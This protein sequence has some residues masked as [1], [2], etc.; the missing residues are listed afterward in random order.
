MKNNVYTVMSIFILL[1]FLVFVLVTYNNKSMLGNSERFATDAAPTW[2]ATA[3]VIPT[4]NVNR[5]VASMAPTNPD[6]AAGMGSPY[7]PS[8]GAGN[9]VYNPVMGGPAAGFG[10]VGGADASGPSSTCYPRDR[11]TADDLLPKDA[12][13]SRWAQMNPSGQGDVNNQNYLTAGF[14]VGINT[15]GQSLRNANRQLRS[16]PPNPQMPVS[17]WNVSTVEYDSNRK[18][19]EIGE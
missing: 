19:F 17:P 14:H 7:A 16:D 9:E 8:D 12:A 11:L 3:G 18:Q 4:P 2:A 6:A 13:N 10:A 5:S 15:Q 1:I